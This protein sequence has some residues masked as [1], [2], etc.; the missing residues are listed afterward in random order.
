MSGW[1]L[2]EID[3]EAKRLQR[4]S[5]AKRRPLEHGLRSERI[6]IR[7]RQAPGKS[8]ETE[9]HSS[10]S[11]VWTDSSLD[12]IEG[13]RDSHEVERPGRAQAY[14]SDHS[15]WELQQDGNWLLRFGVW[16]RNRDAPGNAV[17]L[18]MGGD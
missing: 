12:R 1:R 6:R 10:A 3:N 8:S 11:V 5:W 16:Q 2:I 4:P 13:L 9:C 14:Q 18:G 15:A 7:F 17:E